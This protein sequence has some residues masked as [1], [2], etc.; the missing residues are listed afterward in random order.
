MKI[1]M[2]AGLPGSGKTFFA[3]R[4]AE[5]IN[6]EHVSSDSLRKK[7]F[8]SRNY[9]REE[10]EKVYQKMLDYINEAI[11]G[12]KN[13]IMDATFYREDVRKLFFKTAK[14]F[15]IHIYM[16][17]VTA[18]LP[19]VRK[20]LIQKREDSEADIIVYE[21]LKKQFEPIRENHLVLESQENNIEFMISEA[22]NYIHA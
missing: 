20:R 6:A 2:V 3:S 16:I 5:K 22:L 17:E 15:N 21:N 13:I 10:K 9:S 19:L 18:D 11:S 1:I 14:D 12:N 4:L 8:S 7:M